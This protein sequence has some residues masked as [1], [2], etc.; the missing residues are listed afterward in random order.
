MKPK[1]NLTTE[2]KM[3]MFDWKRSLSIKERKFVY[4]FIE[5][6]NYSEDE[7]KLYNYVIQTDD[8]FSLTVSENVSIN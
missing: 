6:G 7:Y 4:M 3:K 5:N 8:G 2:E 1:L